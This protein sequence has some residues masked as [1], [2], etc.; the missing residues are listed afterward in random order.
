[1]IV[2][3]I[4]I[5]FFSSSNHI[6]FLLPYCSTINSSGASSALFLK[7]FTNSII[8]IAKNKQ[9]EINN[10]KITIT[11]EH[12]RQCIIEKGNAYDFIKDIA[13]SS[14]GGSSSSK[15]P[16]Y[17]QIQNSKSIS[18]QRSRSE[19]SCNNKRSV[20]NCTANSNNDDIIE[21]E[22]KK[23]KI[24]ISDGNGN[25]NAKYNGKGI[26]LGLLEVENSN[27]MNTNLNT[28]KRFSDDEVIEDDE[29]YD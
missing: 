21:E 24:K 20:S 22:Q 17:S 11:P 14:V 9:N 15:I 1:L 5:L 6:L 25:G 29:D 27:Y 28:G 13:E 10:Q 16:N 26:G 2:G 19:T 4:I 3:L 23:K 8:T 7:T 12:I 18:N